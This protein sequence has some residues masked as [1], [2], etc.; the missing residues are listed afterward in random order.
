MV[1]YASPIQS[2][3]HKVSAIGDGYTINLTWYRAYP[4]LLTNKIA[5]H[6]YYACDERCVFAEPPKYVVLDGYTAN[7][8]N[9]APSQ[10]YW[11]SVI[12]VEYDPAIVDYLEELPISH[13]NVRFYP[14]SMLSQD[15]TAT[16]TIIPLMD[17]EGFPPGTEADGYGGIVQIGTELIKYIEILG[18]NLIVASPNSASSIEL[19]YHRNEYNSFQ[20]DGYNHSDG[21]IDGYIPLTGMPSQTFNIVCVFI[22]KDE[23]GNIVPG[24][25]KFECIG[26]ISGN[27]IDGYHV[28]GYG[29]RIGLTTYN[30]DGYGN[31]TVWPADGST[32]SDGLLS[33]A[34]HSGYTPFA[35]G[36]SFTITAKNLSTGVNGGR[37]FNNTTPA[38]HYVSHYD[39]YGPEVSVIAIEEDNNWTN[40]FACQ[41]RFEYPHYQIT[42]LDGPHQV[43]QDFLSTDLE[44]ADAANVGFPEYDYAGYHRT[45]PVQLLSG[46]CVG[47]YIGGQMGC[48]DSHGNYNVYRGFSLQDR[49]LQNQEIALSITGRNAVL[50]RRVQTGDTCSCVLQSSLYPED[51][52]PFCYGTKFV[53]GY[54]Q[55]FNPRSSDGRIK[56]RVSPTAE[57][58]K[59]IE[60]GLDSELPYDMWTLAV[61]TIKMRDII[62]LFDQANNEEFRYEVA[63]VTRNNTILG[64]EGMQKLKSFRIRKTDPAYQIKVM[65]DTSDF[66]STLSTSLGYAVGIPPHAHTIQ[67][68][69]KVLSISQIT[70]TTGIAQGHNHEVIDGVIMPALNHT[71]TIIMP[72]Q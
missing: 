16:D 43:T 34:I 58:L 27:P 64:L 6:I 57:R 53:M 38:P 70:Q 22:Q 51:R 26:S 1:H 4:D 49:N 66:P 9:L 44:A 17:T 2:G 19:T 36:D 7:I 37:G 46:T 71:H 24:E 18:N 12:P 50:I 45:D 21:Y 39:G 32:H 23:Y 56:V 33:F 25:E 14:T 60:A 40:I 67:I 62:I 47:S 65:R 72:T 13:D 54:D 10:D 41:C 63:D 8:I 31:Y 28:D 35:L 29:N 30:G 55:Y 5:Y 11:F 20:P 69:E 52:C 42:T 3:L 68:S 15:I 61:P 48:I 59:M